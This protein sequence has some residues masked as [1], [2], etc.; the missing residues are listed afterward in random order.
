[1]IV[2]PADHTF[3]YYNG[4]VDQTSSHASQLAKSV[5]FF[6]PIQFLFWYDR[7]AMAKD[8]PELEFWKHLPTTWDETKVLHSKIG[9]YAVIA[10]RKSRDWFIGCL[11]AVEP[12]TLDVALDFLPEG[13]RFVAYIYRDD[14]SVPTSTK[15]GIERRHVS[16]KT[17]L[18]VSMRKQGGVAIRIAPRKAD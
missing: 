15:V 11:N 13:Q 9:S 8:E 5:C 1:M 10:R 14:T 17:V 18:K 16:S 7:P 12:R 4:Y 3:Y 2:A 6:S